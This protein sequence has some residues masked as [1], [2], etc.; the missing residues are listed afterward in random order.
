MWSLT[1]VLPVV[2]IV[3]PG[4]WDDLRFGLKVGL[5][6]LMAEVTIL[7]TK[8]PRP[9]PGE[10]PVVG[11][12]WHFPLLLTQ[13][14]LSRTAYGPKKPMV[15]FL[16]R[17]IHKQMTGQ[18]G[19]A[20]RL[21]I[22]QQLHGVTPGIAI[23]FPLAH[24]CHIPSLQPEQNS[25]SASKRQRLWGPP[26]GQPDQELLPVELIHALDAGWVW[27]GDANRTWWILTI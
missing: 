12:H 16:S 8:T 5:M 10:M 19:V 7:C 2:A 24:T 26:A 25:K 13:G 21:L 1:H 17:K 14:Q 20:S 23:C 27:A 22:D 4:L 15:I 9:G 18:G 3:Y 11:S 6:G